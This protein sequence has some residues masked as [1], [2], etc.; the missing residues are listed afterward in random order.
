MVQMISYDASHDLGLLRLADEY[1]DRT[2]W[3]DPA[4]LADRDE[5]YEA[6]ST[7]GRIV[8]CVGFS[9]SIQED[10]ANSVQFRNNPVNKI[11]HS[12]S[13][14]TGHMPCFYYDDRFT[15][16]LG[17]SASLTHLCPDRVFRPERYQLSSSRFG[18]SRGRPKRELSLTPDSQRIVSTAMVSPPETIDLY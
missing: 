11:N 17:L 13:S 8:A 7:G 1:P 3:V 5:I 9:G 2:E 6:K 16:S 18:S 14:L 4:W 15:E 12:D 10:D